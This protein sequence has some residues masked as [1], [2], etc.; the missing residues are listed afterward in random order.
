MVLPA[1]QQYRSLLHR[2]RW[3]LMPPACPRHAWWRRQ[4]S[5][6][7]AWVA[8]VRCACMQEQKV[9]GMC[10]G[11]GWWG[12]KVGVAGWAAGGMP[13]IT[14]HHAI[15]VSQA[16][17]PNIGRAYAAA[18]EEKVPVLPPPPCH[19]AMPNLSHH[20]RWWWWCGRFNN[21][22]PHPPSPPCQTCLT[23]AQKWV[24]EGKQQ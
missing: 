13:T 4:A 21:A 17:M 7:S 2:P 24:G 3:S 5:H 12:G 11:M 22:K 16:A 23:R 18:R 19:H 10:N 6:G 14:P 9:V 15:T 20:P 1:R 8:M